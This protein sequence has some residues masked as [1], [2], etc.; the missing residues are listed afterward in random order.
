MLAAVAAGFTSCSIREMENADMFGNKVSLTVNACMEQTKT[1][2][3]TPVDGVIPVSWASEGESV[4]LLEFVDGSLKQTVADSAYTVEN[5]GANAKFKFALEASEGSSFDYLAVYPGA[6]V[7][8][9][10]AEGSYT[11]FA[12]PDQM[13]KPTATGPDPRSTV[14]VSEM[15]GQGAQPSELNMQFKHVSAYGNVRVKNMACVE[16]E[17]LQFMTITCPEDTLTGVFAYMKDGSVKGVTSLTSIVKIDLRNVA[18]QGTEFETWFASAPFKLNAGD[19]VSVYVSTNKRAF[20]KTVA[21]PADI[22]FTSG[23]ATVLAVDMSNAKVPEAVKADKEFCLSFITPN[24]DYPEWPTSSPSSLLN[25]KTTI[26]GEEYA[27]QVKSTYLNA[28]Q[29]ILGKSGYIGLPAIAN[30]KITRVVV[31]SHK[32]L[33]TYKCQVCFDGAAKQPVAGGAA[34]GW[35]GYP[36]DL[37]F[38]LTDTKAG[39]RVYLCGVSTAVNVAVSKIAVFYEATE[40]EDPEGTA[41]FNMAKIFEGVASGTVVDNLSKNGVNISL[42]KGTGTVDPKWYTELR[43]YGGNTMLFEAPDGKVINSIQFT[44]DTS[45]DRIGPKDWTYDPAGTVSDDTW[46]GSAAKVL[47]SNPTTKQFRVSKIVV[48]YDFAPTGLSPYEYPA[49]PAGIKPIVNLFYGS[50]YGGNAATKDMTGT[51]NFKR[52]ENG[53]E[54]IAED[55]GYAVPGAQVLCPGAASYYVAC[56]SG[57]IYDCYFIITGST[58]DAPLPA[59]FSTPVDQTVS[60]TLELSGSVNQAQGYLEGYKLEWSTTGNDSDWK[61]F[62]AV[63]SEINDTP[64][65]AAAANSYTAVTGKGADVGWYTAEF[66]IPESAPVT[67]GGKLYFKLTPSFSSSMTATRT[68]RTNIGFILKSKTGNTALEGANVIASRNFSDMVAGIN[69]V[70]GVSARYLSY[71]GHGNTLLPNCGTAGTAT[72][73]E[74]GWTPVGSISPRRGCIV[75]TEAGS[76]KGTDVAA[77]YLSPALTALTEPTDIIVTFKACAYLPATD[78]LGVDLRGVGVVKPG[79]AQT[80]KC[81]S[82]ILPDGAALMDPALFNWHRYYAVIKGATA[83]TKVKVGVFKKDCPSGM[84]GRFY[85]DDIVIT[86]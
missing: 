14:L 13:Q 10:A 8:T 48:K 71:V 7:R 58:G 69:P 1:V 56:Q 36:D 73:D 75:P 65:K 9:T 28:V 4:K 3:G 16:G 63:Y 35:A 47:M 72:P 22:D 15:P 77:Y 42:S 12:W 59:F 50:T 86:K 26:D 37:I 70:I 25:V 67:A 44:Y 52:I 2:F 61:P 27:F 78:I 62:D 43:V 41:T 60:G 85:L 74:Y 18:M 68:F 19:T 80:V 55:H 83:E 45:S 51:I 6:N 84:D 76:P 34:Q 23:S 57:K 5:G 33:E 30:H 32:G 17:T 40:P 66:T 54:F 21:S 49:E 31:G 64:E 11:T 53:I 46:T 79:D 29:C 20:I 82:P 24:V 38:D 81:D 39:E